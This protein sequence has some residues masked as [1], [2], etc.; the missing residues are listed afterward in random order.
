MRPPASQ[1]SCALDDCLRITHMACA[2]R[3]VRLLAS[4]QS[5]LFAEEETLADP[6]RYDA[7]APLRHLQVA[8]KVGYRRVRIGDDGGRPSGDRTHNRRIIR[9]HLPF[10]VLRKTPVDEVVDRVDVRTRRKARG[11]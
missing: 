5:L 6:E 8:L 9:P 2:S 11:I 4:L 10:E 1:G 7:R 3:S